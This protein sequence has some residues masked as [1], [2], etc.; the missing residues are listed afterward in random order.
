M[1]GLAYKLGVI[2]AILGV[3]SVLVLILIGP[4][5]LSTLLRA[6]GALNELEA[7]ESEKYQLLALVVS[8]FGLLVSMVGTASTIILGWRA[9]RRQVESHSSRLK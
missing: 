5:A 8:A 4:D 6:R 7:V 9:E 2:F 3:C 1:R